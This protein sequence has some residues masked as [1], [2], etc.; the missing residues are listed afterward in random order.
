MFLVP[1]CVWGIEPYRMGI[2]HKPMDEGNEYLC[3]QF[4]NIHIEDCRNVSDTFYNLYYI[5]EYSGSDYLTVAVEKEYSSSIPVTHV[6]EPLIAHILT[7]NLPVN[8]WALIR[9]IAKNEYGST[10]CTMDLPPKW[11]NSASLSD[12]VINDWNYDFINVYNISGVFLRAIEN[13]VELQYLERGM[14]ILE[15]MDGG[16]YIYRKKITKK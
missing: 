3:P 1:M 14:Y 12:D 2:T 15:Y 4:K 10:I 7:E 6:R 11:F 9:I 16:R 8:Y 5:V 13:D